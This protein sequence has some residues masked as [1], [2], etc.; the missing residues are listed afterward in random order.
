MSAA[1]VFSPV[2]GVKV[3][4]SAIHGKGVFTT[5]NIPGGK[6][7]LA[8]KKTG[9]SGDPGRDWERTII[10][11]YANHANTPNMDA[12]RVENGVFFVSRRPIKKGTELTV[13]YGAVEMA[14][15]DIVS[16][17][18]ELGAPPPIRRRLLKIALDMVRRTLARDGIDAYVPKEEKGFH[19][20][21]HV[22]AKNK[23]EAAA[24]S[25]KLVRLFGMEVKKRH[26]NGTHLLFLPHLIAVVVNP[27]KR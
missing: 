22:D 27:K 17:L 1:K 13:S 20:D 2:L 21:L 15:S 10:G 12:K 19:M 26:A 6:I 24:V 9:Q 5:L 18:A 14:M 8:L 25:A 4:P 11:R 16:G 7:F 3:A 23:A